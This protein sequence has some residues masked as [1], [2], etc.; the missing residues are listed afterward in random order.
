V[1]KE[2]LPIIDR[3]VIQYAV[4]EAVASGIKEIVLVTSQY[5]RAI[6]DY[7]DR[8][9]EL[10]ALLERRNDKARL[11]QVQ[12][13]FGMANIYAVRQG[14]QKGLGHAVLMAKG[15][16]G[17]EPFAAMLPDDIMR[18]NK[19]PVMRQL[20]DVHERYKASVMALLPVPMK[21]VP[22]YGIVKAKAV[23]PK[24]HRVLNVVEKPKQE[25]APSNLASMG[26]YVLSSR[27]FAILEKQ[28]PG[29]IG[30]IQLAEAIGTL[31]KEEAVYGL[32]YEGT[33][34]DAGTPLGLLKASVQVALERP[35]TRDDIRAFLK[36]VLKDGR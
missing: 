9:F 25:E 26:R 8:T 32:E 17:N 5:K 23:K 18:A 27:I 7:F 2:L 21:E 30:E 12:A 13:L 22:R 10:E 4:E 20:L 16:V 14:E 24:L 34:L 31:A 3:P 35:D 29:A 36:G 6:E 28:K 11:E 19:K 33:L 15:I 1:P